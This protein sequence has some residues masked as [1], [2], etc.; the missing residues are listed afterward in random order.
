MRNLKVENF[1]PIKK[2]EVSF[3]DLTIIVGQQASGKSLFLQLFKLIC[4]AGSIRKNLHNH[5][6]ESAALE[7]GMELFF[8]EGMTKLNSSSTKISVG[9]KNHKIDDLLAS[10]S[11]AAESVFY[12][13]AQ[14]V[15]TI[16]DGWPRNFNNYNAGDPYVVKDFSENLRQLMDQGLGRG[17]APIFP[18]DGKL[19]SHLRDRIDKSI[20][21]GAK[22]TLEKGGL[23][24][25][26]M[27]NV[28]GSSLPYMT[29]SAGQREFMPLLLGLY[30]LIPSSA[31]QKR[32]D[33]KYVVIEEPEMGLHPAAIKSLLLLFFELVARGY[34]VIVSTHSPVILEGI[35]ALQTLKKLRAGPDSIFKLLDI[36]PHRNQKGLL[37][38]YSA[39]LEK[40]T[41]CYLF[42][43]NESGTEVKDISSLDPF[44]EDDSISEWGGITSFSTKVNELISSLVK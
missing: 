8:G 29:W 38:S 36:P 27:L 42:E 32:D 41:A 17:E 23:K 33:I 28:S 22:V 20:F 11:R 31:K 10:R 24:K 6:F 30:W 13:P 3:G 1:G 18:Q 2:A 40:K 16:Q 15:I 43:R 14:R 9:V 35:W 26:F 39:L 37:D 21:H 44:S 7:Y 34:K 5:G 19:K 12:V 25:R 4:D